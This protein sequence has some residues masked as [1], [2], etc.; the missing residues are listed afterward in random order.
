MSELNTL[1]GS[2]EVVGGWGLERVGGEERGRTLSVDHT[3]H[4]AGAVRRG[5]LQDSS[6]VSVRTFLLVAEFVVICSETSTTKATRI[7]FFT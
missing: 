6:G 4:H 1:H 3:G 5:G 7:G 2:V